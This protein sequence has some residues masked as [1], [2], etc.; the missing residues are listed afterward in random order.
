MHTSFGYR[1][2]QIPSEAKNFSSG[3]P[4]FFTKK[5][6]DSWCAQ[7]EVKS[8][9]TRSVRIQGPKRLP[10]RMTSV[11]SVKCFPASAFRDPSAK[12]SHSN[13]LEAKG[14]AFLDDRSG[15][16]PLHLTLSQSVLKI[17]QITI[18]YSKFSVQPYD[19]TYQKPHSKQA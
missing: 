10:W 6:I 12:P 18:A 3:W 5:R 13:H 19:T 17:H 14:R 8:A 1:I 16:Y 15:E 9:L 11:Y 4:L 2:H 7:R